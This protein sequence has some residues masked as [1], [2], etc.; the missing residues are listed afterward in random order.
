MR[1]FLKNT[2]INFINDWLVYFILLVMLFSTTMYIQQDFQSA[3]AEVFETLYRIK[4]KLS[5][6]LS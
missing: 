5:L 4:L 2:T 6:F 1:T 3:Y